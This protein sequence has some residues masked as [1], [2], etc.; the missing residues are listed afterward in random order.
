[1]RRRREPPAA[2]ADDVPDP[3]RGAKGDDMQ[4]LRAIMVAAL[5][6]LP[7]GGGFAE[8]AKPEREGVH[9]LTSEELE[10][11]FRGHSFSGY[12]FGSGRNFSE[13]HHPDGRIIGNNGISINT[14][15]CWYV[16]EGAICYVY[17]PPKD[18]RTYCFVMHRTG[19]S[20]T[21][22]LTVLPE[23]RLVGIGVLEEGN[24]HNLT[25]PNDWT[26]EAPIARAPM[27][28]RPTAL[29]RA[30]LSDR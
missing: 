5:L 20:K 4:I 10:K 16:R 17:G 22:T 25:P 30:R 21:M 28:L 29:A 19:A 7:I 14:D 2:T 12:H 6:F 9:A 27:S 3:K 15:G 26:C 18:R 13:Y 23:K 11:L 8:E 1:M 24:P